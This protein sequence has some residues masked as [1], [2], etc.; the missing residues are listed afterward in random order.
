MEMNNNPL[1]SI[2]TSTYKKFDYIYQ[3]IESVLMQDYSNI[4]YIITDDGSDNFPQSEI[5]KFIINKGNAKLQ[6]KIIH[7]PFNGGTVKNLNN[8]YRCSRGNYILN[9]S[10]GDAFV[11]SSTV[12]EI[13]EKFQVS[14]NK[15]IVT[16]RALYD[17]K[18]VID[19][20]PHRREIKI[21]NEWNNKQQFESFLKSKYYDMASGSA[22]YFERSIFDE[23]GF[24]DEAYRLWEDGPFL[25]KYLQNHSLTFCFDLISIKYLC[26]GVS[27]SSEPVSDIYMKDVIRFNT[28]EKANLR[29]NVGF[30]TKRNISYSIARSNATNRIGVIKTYIMY[31]DQVFAYYLY[32]KKRLYYKKMD[33]D[34]VKCYSEKH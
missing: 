32:K 10:C 21:I 25:A 6:Y 18:K 31:F 26:G 30:W 13:I 19:I 12:R 34:F 17:G 22:M 20:I 16:G 9:L 33:R 24:Y 14:S 29:Q 8:A 15:V 11:S 23:I 28:I 27:D 4:E 5:E 7:H 2:I 1:V 3:T